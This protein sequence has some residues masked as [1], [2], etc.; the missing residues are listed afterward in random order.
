MEEQTKRCTWATLPRP[1][2]PDS[3]LTFTASIFVPIWSKTSRNSCLLT[4]S[5]WPIYRFSI[6]SFISFIIYYFKFIVFLI[7]F[8]FISLCLFYIQGHFMNYRDSPESA[9]RYIQ[10]LK[11]T[12]SITEQTIINQIQTSIQNNLLNSFFYNT[13]IYLFFVF[14]ITLQFCKLDKYLK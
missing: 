5:L 3:S 2:S 4:T 13:F 6:L 12:P 7:Y 11:H 9:L 14:F 8:I 10:N 1:R